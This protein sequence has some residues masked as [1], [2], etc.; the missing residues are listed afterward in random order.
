MCWNNWKKLPTSWTSVRRVV[1]IFPSLFLIILCKTKF[2]SHDVTWCAWHFRPVGHLQFEPELHLTDLV[3]L[4]PP[5]SFPGEENLILQASSDPGGGF[6]G[7]HGGQRGGRPGQHGLAHH[8]RRLPRPSGSRAPRR[9]ALLGRAD[10]GS[11]EWWERNFSPH[12]ESNMKHLK[13]SIVFFSFCSTTPRRAAQPRGQERG[14]DPRLLHLVRGADQ[15]APLQARAREGRANLRHQLGNHRLLPVALRQAAPQRDGPHS[16][17][18]H[19][20]RVL[21][22]GC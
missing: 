18:P 9:A 14:G 1:S 21:L 6:L 3:T 13:L 2:I 15:R 22:T 12:R 7:H 8:V 5:I 10:A 4:P 19:A 20:Q 11:E 16:H 17:T